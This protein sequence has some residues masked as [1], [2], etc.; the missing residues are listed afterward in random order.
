[1][2]GKKWKTKDDQCGGKN[3]KLK[4]IN[5]GKKWKTN[6]DQCGEKNGNLKM[7][8]TQTSSKMGRAGI[9]ALFQRSS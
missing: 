4:M 1:M 8:N 7:S 9:K 3:G 2:W 5:V 6:D